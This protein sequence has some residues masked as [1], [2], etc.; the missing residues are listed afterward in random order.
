M[1]VSRSKK[2]PSQVFVSGFG[3][4]SWKVTHWP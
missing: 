2:E 3:S 1:K 4:G